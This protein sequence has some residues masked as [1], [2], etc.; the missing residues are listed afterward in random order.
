ASAQEG[1]LISISLY[2]D[3]EAQSADNEHGSQEDGGTQRV[4]LDDK[5][6]ARREKVDYDLST[7]L[8]VQ[9]RGTDDLDT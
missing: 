2:D 8:F 3:V 9:G 7:T 5:I 1:T 4:A 6:E